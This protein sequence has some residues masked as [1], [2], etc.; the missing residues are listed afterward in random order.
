MP[1][2]T[3]QSRKNEREGTKYEGVY[4]RTFFDKKHEGKPVISFTIDYYHPV[5]K[6]RIRETVGR[7]DKGNMTAKL[8][9]KIR[10]SRIENL[11]KGLRDGFDPQPQIAPTLGEAW[12]KYHDDWLVAHNKAS[13]PTDESLWKVHYEENPIRYRALDKIVLID[14]ENIVV[15]KRNE[16]L[17]PQTIVHILALMRRIMNRA[18][19]WEL[20]TPA[21]NVFDLFSMPE[22][23]NE[24][25][26]FLT[27][28]RCAISR[29][30]RQT[31]LPPERRKKYRS[32]STSPR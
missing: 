15:Q 11:E 7:S 13:R 16:G 18:K 14:L 30:H 21:K 29:S 17:A 32:K 9:S 31:P 22:V 27:E 24:R 3:E 8:A 19:K 23:D 1:A 10:H 5:T 28:Y 2:A 4:Q 25:T 6:K 12:Q 26:R 20:W